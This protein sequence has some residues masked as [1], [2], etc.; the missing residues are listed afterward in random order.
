M[1]LKSETTPFTATHSPGVGI[2]RPRQALR[3][4]HRRNPQHALKFRR[5][6]GAGESMG[7]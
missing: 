1:L 4:S 3:P 2:P 7:K 6:P 5:L